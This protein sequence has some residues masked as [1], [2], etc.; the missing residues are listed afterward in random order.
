MTDSNS[1]AAQAAE[2]TKRKI[3]NTGD[4]VTETVNAVRSYAK[5]AVDTAGSKLDRAQGAV[6][7]AVDDV[8]ARIVDAPIQSSLIAMGIGACLA[9]ARPW[10]LLSVAAVAA[11]AL[12]RLTTSGSSSPLGRSSNQ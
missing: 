7:Q 1:P 12:Q 10:R 9:I 8:R 11:L 2:A 6:D 5:D 4:Q 3:D